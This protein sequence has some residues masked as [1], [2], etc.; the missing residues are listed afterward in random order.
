MQHSNW[1]YW[2][3]RQ[4]QALTAV[5]AVGELE[6]LGQECRDSL[7]ATSQMEEDTDVMSDQLCWGS[8]AFGALKTT[9][10]TQKQ[11]E[12]TQELT[13]AFFGILLFSKTRK[14][15]GLPP[16]KLNELLDPKAEKEFAEWKFGLLAVS[17][18]L[19]NPE[20]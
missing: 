3:K 15:Q 12:F 8:G 16:V 10:Q 17:M 11:G 4:I 19:H 13:D 6:L 7:L 14:P 1:K 18:G 2:H 9:T 20:L 5:G